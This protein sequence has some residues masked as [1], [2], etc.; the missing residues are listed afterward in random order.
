[1]TYREMHW[2]NTRNPRAC[3][4]WK[5]CNPRVSPAGDSESSSIISVIE[6]LPPLAT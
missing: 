5:P 6:E 1:M 2:G 4:T 3:R